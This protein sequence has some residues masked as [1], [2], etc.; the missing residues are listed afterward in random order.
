MVNSKILIYDGSFNGFLTAIFTA[1]DEHIPVSDIQSN[2]IKQNGLFSETRTIFTEMDK[3]KRVWNALQNK[4]NLVIRTIYFAY[5]SG[6][7]GIEELLYRYIKKLYMPSVGESIGNMGPILQKINHLATCV[8]RE[9]ERLERSL[10]FYLTNDAVYFATIH[11]DFD[12]LPLISK[13]FR[14]RFKDQA[15]VIYDQKRKYGLYYDLEGVEIISLDLPFKSNATKFE[16]AQ[17][18]ADGNGDK[19][20][21]DRIISNMKIKTCIQQKLHAQNIPKS[22]IQYA[23]EKKVG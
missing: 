19:D 5:L 18:A 1:F 17:L 9:K 2:T 11:P 10:G 16:S 8:A 14:Y 13:H 12:V 4:N 23:R 15:W 20:S 7:E 6:Y 22:E 3:A 21:L